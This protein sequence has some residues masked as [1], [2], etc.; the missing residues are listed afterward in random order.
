M[1]H[2]LQERY[3]ALV[4]A[5]L[6][7]TLVTKDNLIFNNKYEGNPKAGLVKIPVRDKEVEVINYDKT[8]GIA[9]GESATT[10]LDLVLDKDIAV[11]ELI[12][13][14]DAVAVPDNIVADRIESAG[15][16][17]GLTIDKASIGVLETQGTKASDKVAVDETNAYKKIMKARTELSKAGVPAQGRF[18]I[19]SPEVMESIMQDDR[20]IKQGDLSQEL[21]MA[22]VVGKIA[23]FNVFE[24]C[25]MGATTEFI[26]GHPD[27]CHRVEEWQVPVHVQDLSGSGSYIGASAV[28]G[29]KIFGVK[30][31]KAKAVYVKQNA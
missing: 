11:N 31:S 24:S 3:S 7:K 29:R 19:A 4:D 21:V 1:A 9:L 13:G 20:F 26:C 22:G 14:F 30:V 5:K 15:Y 25:N 17:L 28:Q 6:R 10:Y 8:N 23:G 16:S 18:L 12:D 27:Y 2:N